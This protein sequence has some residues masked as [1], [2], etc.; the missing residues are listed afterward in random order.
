MKIQQ[1]IFLT[2]NEYI[3]QQSCPNIACS[4]HA[5]AG[6]QYVAIHDQKETR[7]RGRECGKTRGAHYKEFYYGLHTEQ[8][9]IRRAIELL[10]ARIPIRTIA[11]FVKVSPS[12]VMRWKKKLFCNQCS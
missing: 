1:Q 9:K 7:F 4:N 2:M 5:K 3:S 11:R 10:K 8:I 6:E 12:T